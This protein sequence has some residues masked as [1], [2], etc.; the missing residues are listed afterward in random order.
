[1]RVQMFFIRVPHRSCFEFTLAAGVGSRM[2][3]D[4]QKQFLRSKHATTP[5][6]LALQIYNTRS[7]YFGGFYKVHDS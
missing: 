2:K 1:M 6:E 4:C 5:G 7:E 3:V